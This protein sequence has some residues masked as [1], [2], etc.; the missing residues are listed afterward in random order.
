MTMPIETL[1]GS[2]TWAP[3]VCAWAKRVFRETRVEHLADVDSMMAGI[4]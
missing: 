4:R 1:Y 2:I 3:I